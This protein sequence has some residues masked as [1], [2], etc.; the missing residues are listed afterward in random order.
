MSAY[1]DWKCGAIT[2][3]QYTSE[4]NREASMDR[5]DDNKC[6]K[7][8]FYRWHKI[9]RKMF[10]RCELDEGCIYDDDYEEPEE[11]EEEQEIINRDHSGC[12]M[13]SSCCGDC[14]QCDHRFER[15]EG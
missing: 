8:Q 14:S 11:K 13:S 1:S 3:E 7:C 12:E 4:C 15:K 6:H 2:D 10:R 5:E 9:G